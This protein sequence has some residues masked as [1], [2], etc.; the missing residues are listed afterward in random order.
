[1]KVEFEL[2]IDENTGDPKIRFRHYDKSSALEQRVLQI[3]IKKA[4]LN[5]LRIVNISGFLSSQDSWEN[6]EILPSTKEP[7]NDKE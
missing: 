6:Y 1:M 2:T 5:G 3:F 7:D 4:R